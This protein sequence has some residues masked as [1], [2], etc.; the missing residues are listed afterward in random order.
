MIDMPRAD[1][2]CLCAQEQGAVADNGQHRRTS[3]SFSNEEGVFPN[4]SID[5]LPHSL[6][7]IEEMSVK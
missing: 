1:A 7:I 4:Y 6:E 5:Y 2:V 3:N